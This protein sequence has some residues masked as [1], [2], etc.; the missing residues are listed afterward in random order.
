MVP[1]QACGDV[2]QSLLDI[3]DNSVAY[4]NLQPTL[5]GAFVYLGIQQNTAAN[6]KGH[7]YCPI[8]NLKNQ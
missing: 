4:V 8:H 7:V 2:S 3:T 1:P 6:M 5:Q